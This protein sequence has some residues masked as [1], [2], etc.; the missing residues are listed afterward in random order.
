MGQATPLALITGATSRIGTALAHD[1]AAHGWGLA[2]HT[3][4]NIGAAENL[5]SEAVRLGARSAKVVKAD[6]TNTDALSGLFTRIVGE[7]GI[8][9]VIINNASIFED[10]SIGR[11][12]AALFDAHYHIHARA[13]VFLTDALA[14]ALPQDTPGLVVNIIDQRVWK[15]TPQALSYTLSKAA[16]WTATQTMA[17]ALAPHIRVNGIGPGPSFKNPRQTDAEFA[18]QTDG[19]LM[20]AGPKPDDFGRTVRYLWETP[21]ITGQ[22]IALDGGQHLAWATPDVTDVGE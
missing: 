3:H 9:Q 12:D 2:L 20:K 17:Q 10:D 16:L 13:P 19:V 14:A 22:M 18:R 21:S 1:L 8:P 11:L 4:N 15:L 7:T 6:L 5:S